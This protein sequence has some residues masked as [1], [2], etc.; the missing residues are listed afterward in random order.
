M[1]VVPTANASRP[2][3][4]LSRSR[5]ERGRRLVANAQFDDLLAEVCP[6]RV[7]RVEGDDL[8]LVHD[9]QPVAEP[10]GLVEV[11]GREQDRR[12][13]RDRGDRRSGRAAPRGHAGRGRPS[14]RRG[15][16]RWGATRAPGRSRAAAA[17]PRCRCRRG[18]RAGRR[19]RAFRTALAIRSPASL[20]ATRHRRAWMS[21]WL[22]PVRARS[23]TA[24]WKTTLET[25]RASSGERTTSKPASRAVPELGAHRGREHAD[26][27]RLPGSVRT[28]QAEHLAAVDVEADVP[29]RAHVSGVGLHELPDL[30]CGI[31]RCASSWGR[32]SHRAA[33][34][35][36][37][38]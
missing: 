8:A 12:L 19:G 2:A 17:R 6:Q 32:L 37:D 30:D 10:L 5:C 16:A 35:A 28:E 36:S 20:G 11:V 31:H 15:R 23:T 27:R 14:A 33:W 26:R 22:R 25:E 21:R 7:R 3:R 24:S 1:I 38:S 4:P 34:D 9:R 18:G 13:Q 29:D